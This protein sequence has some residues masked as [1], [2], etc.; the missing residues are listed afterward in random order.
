MQ[1]IVLRVA[2]EGCVQRSDLTALTH[3][4][5]EGLGLV[6]GNG[7]PRQPKIAIPAG[8]LARAFHGDQRGER[9]NTIAWLSR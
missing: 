5:T 9:S 4:P 6:S 3:R 8:G 2:L 7:A 1:H